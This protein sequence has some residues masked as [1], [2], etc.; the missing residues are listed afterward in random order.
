[1]GFG[2]DEVRLGSRVY[3]LGPR[4]YGSGFRGKS[5]GFGGYK[6]K[7]DHFMAPIYPQF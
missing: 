3:V 7:F 5:S 4:V 1:M 6:V 2:G